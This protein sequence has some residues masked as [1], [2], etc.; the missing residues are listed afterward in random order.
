MA[1]DAES[2]TDSSA[3]TAALQADGPALAAAGIAVAALVVGVRFRT[4]STVAVLATAAVVA[5]SDPAPL[6]AALSG[7]SAVAY[8]LLRHGATFTRPTVVGALGFAAVGLAA[9]AVP[10][11]LAWV[12][13]V[14]PLA[15][16]ALYLLVVWPFHERGA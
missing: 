13:L 15:V 6:S 5:L 12:P 10:L 14:A 3:P 9:T 16:P 11:E 2:S 4:V 7:L 8:L 1:I